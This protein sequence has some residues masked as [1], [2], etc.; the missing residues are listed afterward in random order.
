LLCHLKNGD[1]EQ[2]T[3]LTEKAMKDIKGI[4]E[5]KLRVKDKDTKAAIHR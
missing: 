1:V 3:A 5:G 2:T 4:N